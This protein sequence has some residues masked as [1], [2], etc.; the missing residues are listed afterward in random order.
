MKSRNKLILGGCAV[1]LTFSTAVLIST[2]QKKENKQ[3]S[4]TTHNKSP[5]IKIPASVVY[6]A[7]KENKLEPFEAYIKQGGSLT[8]E[9]DIEGKKVTLAQAIVEHERLEFIQKAVTLAPEVK[10]HVYTHDSKEIKNANGALSQLSEVGGGIGTLSAAAANQLVPLI[11]AIAKSSKPNLKSEMLNLSKDNPEV[12][13]GIETAASEVLPQAVETCDQDQIRFLGDLGANPMAKNQKGGNA[14]GAAGKTKCFN[15]ISYWK[16]EQN[17]D[18]DEKNEEGISGFDVL[19]RFKDPELQSF[20]DTLQ[21]EGVREIASL[22][23][24]VKRVSF[25]RKR[26]PSAIIDPEALVEPE[27][28]PDEATET[29]EFSEFSD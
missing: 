10:S 1:L 22:K 19:S 5:E 8:A 15:A 4:A 13:S 9:V 23:P 7:I 17:I 16:K 11:G 27:L 26:V 14:L 2:N 6:E 24:K 25:Y 29:A 20:T 18:F 12:L 21:E 3:A 28:R